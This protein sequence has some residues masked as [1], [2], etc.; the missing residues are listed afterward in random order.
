MIDFFPLFNMHTSHWL[1][2]LYFPS[3]QH[4]LLTFLTIDE[5]T[6]T[7]HCQL[8]H[9]TFLSSPSQ[10]DSGTRNQ[11]ELTLGN[12]AGCFYILV[13]GL[14]LAMCVAFIEFI[15]KSKAE[16]IRQKVIY[17]LIESLFC[18]EQFC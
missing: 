10:Q 7:G 2:S 9:V 11:S 18:D 13:G 5:S 15:L 12:V 8:I 4:F 3:R 6:C 14:L 16:A 1:L 17:M